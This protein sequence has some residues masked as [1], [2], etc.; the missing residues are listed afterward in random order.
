MKPVKVKAVKLY[1]EVPNCDFLRNEKELQKGK[2][3]KQVAAIAIDDR[4]STQ[5]PNSKLSLQL[6][7]IFIT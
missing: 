5:S 6:L 7:C 3:G 2:L 1:T 4:R